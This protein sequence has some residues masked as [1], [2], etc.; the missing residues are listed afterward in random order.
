MVNSLDMEWAN[1]RRAELRLTYTDA[2]S[3]LGRLRQQRGEMQ[4]ALG[5][6]LRAAA[7]Q[8]HREDLARGIMS[9][10]AELGQQDRALAVYK[11]LVEE[12]K[13]TFGVAPDPQT[14]ELMDIIRQR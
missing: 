3:T 8:P 4:E 14:T 13:H 5:L 2:L 6:Y 11:H 1:S 12:L 7:T 9:L 10:Y